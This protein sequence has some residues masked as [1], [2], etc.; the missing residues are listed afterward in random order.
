MKSNL[1]MVV[2]AVLALSG[3]IF[4][5]YERSR[6]ANL[7]IEKAELVKEV[8]EQRQR[9]EEFQKMA[10]LAQQEAEIQRTICEEQLKDCKSK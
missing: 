10:A 4:G 7:E 8:E 9:A 1:S 2:F 5:L 3:V 6:A